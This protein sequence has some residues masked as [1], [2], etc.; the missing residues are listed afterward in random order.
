MLL[1]ILILRFELSTHPCCQWPRRAPPPYFSSLY[2][3]VLD[4]FWL[5]SF[6]VFEPSKLPGIS[7]WDSAPMTMSCSTLQ[8]CSWSPELTVQPGPGDFGR[9]FYPICTRPGLTSERGPLRRDLQIKL[10]EKYFNID[11]ERLGQEH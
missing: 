8:E 6:R 7:Q 2:S 3:L 5:C 10:F 9:L 11:Y 4:L 1:S